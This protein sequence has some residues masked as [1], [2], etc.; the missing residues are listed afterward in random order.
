MSFAR[1]GKAD[2]NERKYPFIVEVPAAAN[3]LNVELNSQIVGFYN[4]DL[5][6]SMGTRQ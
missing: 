1:A 2:V 3:G 6:F 5:F 4:R